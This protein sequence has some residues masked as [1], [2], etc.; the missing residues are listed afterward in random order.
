MSAMKRTRLPGPTF[1]VSGK[2][3]ARLDLP[4]SFASLRRSSQSKPHSR[5]IRG[6]VR[7]HAADN[8]PKNPGPW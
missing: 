7:R 1:W 8:E 6:N 2:E 3:V 5:P 4:Q